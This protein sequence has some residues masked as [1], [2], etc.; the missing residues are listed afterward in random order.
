MA[1]R[2]LDYTRYCIL[3]IYLQV[4]DAGESAQLAFGLVMIVIAVILAYWV[5]KDATGRGRDNALLWALGIGILTLLTLL[6]GL[7]ALAVYIYTRD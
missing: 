5:Y 2:F 1:K 3:M 7:I 4:G 6:G